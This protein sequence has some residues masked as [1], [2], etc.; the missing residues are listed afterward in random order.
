MTRPPT[1]AQWR[2][3]EAADPRTGRISGSEAQLTRLVALKLAFRHPRPPHDHFLTPAG[4]RL[5][6]AGDEPAG[7][8]PT[9]PPAAGAPAAGSDGVFTARLGGEADAVASA[10]RAREVRTA[11]QG[12]LEIRRMTSADGSTDRPCAW[13]RSRL[14]HAAALALEAAGCLPA[15]GTAPGYRVTGTPQP[16]AVA[17]H[18][19]EPASLA[20][21]AV[22]LQEAGWQVSE[23]AATRG[24]GRYLLASPRRA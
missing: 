13:E 4:H 18:H 8:A 1:A 23:H 12:L 2:I 22:A 9:A 19:P 20:A 6:E 3:I 17:V 7:P 11:W 21:C 14:T 10:A 5:R 24:G 16:E 15:T